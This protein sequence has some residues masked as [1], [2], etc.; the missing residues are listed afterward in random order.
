MRYALIIAGGSGTRLWPMSTQ[1]MPKQLIPFINGKSLLQIAVERLEKVL[2]HDQIFICAGSSMKQAILDGLPNFSPNNFIEEPTG[3]DTLNAIALS[4]A[5]LAQ[6]NPD[7]VVGVFSADQVIEPVDQFA[8]VVDTGYQIAE[9]T[10][11]SLVT[12]GIKPTHP[13]TGYGYLQL[14]AALPSNNGLIVDQYKE[15]PDLST[16]QA[17]LD[18]GPDQYLWNSGMFVWQAKTLLECVKRYTPDNYTQIKSITDALDTPQYDAILAEVYPKLP[19]ISVDYAVMEPASQDPDIQVIATPMPIQWLDVG[20]WPSFK[21]V[22]DHDDNQNAQP[23]TKS[24]LIDTQNTLVASN[25]PNHLVTVLGCS[26]LIV[27]HTPTSTLVCHKDHAE[28]IKNLHSQIAET[29]GPD[30]L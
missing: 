26:D 14:G 27:I 20:S 12:F 24:T 13:A 6:K 15:K 10:P 17:Y 21:T 18:A 22:C 7:A 3:R 28:Q 16:A 1:A 11:D 23:N 19:R 2:P 30:Y 5:I 25:D 29:H 4:T 8:S 9:S